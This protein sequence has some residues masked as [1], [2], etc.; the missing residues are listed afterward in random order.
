[1]F[2]LDNSGLTAVKIGTSECHNIT[3]SGEYLDWLAQGNT[4]L[5]A[6]HPTPEELA[7]IAQRQAD[8]LEAAEAKADATT[9]YLVNHTLIE[10]NNYIRG[11]INTPA[12]TNLATATTSLK[13]METL[14][15]KLAAVVSI[16]AKDKLR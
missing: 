5:P 8:L 2:K 12:V 6:D 11:K 9:Q 16:L 3:L 4:P 1:M 13:E 10:I 14:L 7:A 15:I